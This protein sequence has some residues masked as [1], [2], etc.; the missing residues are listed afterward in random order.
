M[1]IYNR[2]DINTDSVETLRE[3]AHPRNASAKG[4]CGADTVFGAG[5]FL[6][7]IA[8]GFFLTSG[9]AAAPAAPGDGDTLPS[10]MLADE[11]GLDGSWT[12]RRGGGAPTGSLLA[13][14]FWNGSLDAHF[15]EGA[16][17]AKGSRSKRTLNASSFFI[18]GR[19]ASLSLRRRHAT[20]DASRP[21]PV[22]QPRV[23]SA[24][25]SAPPSVSRASPFAPPGV[26]GTCAP[27]KKHGDCGEQP[28]DAQ[29]TAGSQYWASVDGERKLPQSKFG[30]SVHVLGITSEHDAYTSL[31]IA[32][33]AR[34]ALQTPAAEEARRGT[35]VTRHKVYT[36]VAS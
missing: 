33:L 28:S 20:T 19:F 2:R 12:E 25:I 16:A 8:P 24:P 22:Q 9:G 26:T 18:I 11:A 3:C 14:I 4:S 15:P 21:K 17:L 5:V 13:P 29:R 35:T 32:S 23:M 36:R 30:L 7:P 10:S 27:G 1:H 31:D 6:G 34:A